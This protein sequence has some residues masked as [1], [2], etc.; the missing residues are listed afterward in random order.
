MPPL[1]S[2]A[3][4]FR[5][6]KTFLLQIAL[7]SFLFKRLLK[8]SPKQSFKGGSPGSLPNLET[9]HNNLTVY[10]TELWTSRGLPEVIHEASTEFQVGSKRLQ[11][12][13]KKLPKSPKG[14]PKGSSHS[15]ASH[16]RKSKTFL[17]QIVL[18]SFL[19]KLLLNSSPKQSFKGGS[20]GSLQ[21]LKTLLNNLTV[22]ATEL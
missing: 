10:A 18:P 15:P 19:F 13:S 16:F 8:S 12:A 2:P 1:P 22:Y 4:N 17:L 9:L 14:L 20:P 3:S 6:S 5:K 7:P 21:N 11:R